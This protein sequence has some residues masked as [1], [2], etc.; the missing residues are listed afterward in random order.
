MRSSATSDSTFATPASKA[1]YSAIARSRPSAVDI[2]W[3]SCAKPL[4]HMPPLRPEAAPA[5]RPASRTT[6]LAPFFASASAADSPVKPAPTT[7][8]SASPAG[9]PLAADVNGGAVSSQ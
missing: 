9:G 7:T 4:L 3:K 6:T 2:E 1:R 8:T 5:T